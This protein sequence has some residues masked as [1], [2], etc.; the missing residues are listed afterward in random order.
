MNKVICFLLSLLMG[1]SA[2]AASTIQKDVFAVETRDLGYYFTVNARGQVL[3]QYLGK[4]VNSLNDFKYMKD[5]GYDRIR[6]QDREIYTTFG[7][8]NVDI[9]ALQVKHA[10][11]NMTTQL[12]LSEVEKKQLSADLIQ[13]TIKLKDNFYPFYVD[14]V[15]LAHQTSNVIETYTQIR[16][17]ESGSVVVRKAASSNLSMTAD[18][19]YLTH[20]YGE[21]SQEMTEVE[22][23]LNLGVKTIESQK[24]VRTSTSEHPTFFLSLNAPATETEG[25][26]ILGSLAWSGNYKL[27]FQYDAVNKMY[28][29]SGMNDFMSDYLLKSG[30]SFETPKFIFTYSDQGKGQASRNFHKWARDY[31][32]Y[33][34]RQVRPLVLNSWEGAYFNFD[35]KTIL[36]MIDDA[37]TMGVEMF[38]L[39]DGWFGNKYPRDNDK[40][41][42]GDWAINKKKL[43]NGLKPF[44]D[45]CKE[46]GMQFG[47]W[48]EPEMINPKSELAEKHPEW[49]MRS[50]NRE[51]LFLRNQLDLDLSNPQV[52]DF[53]FDVVDKTLTETPGITYVKWDENR[54]VENFG[55]TYLP[56]QQQSELWI[57]YVQ[58]LNK[59]YERLRAKYPNVIFQACAS[60]GGRSDYGTM[61]YHNEFWASDN[62]DA[63]SRVKINWGFSNIYPANAIA[64]HVSHVPNH[65]TKRV[66]PIKFRFDVAMAQRLGLELQPRKLDSTETAWTHLA[67]PEFKKIRE[68][69][70]LGELYRLL[71]PY[72]GITTAKMYVS[73]NKEKAVLFTYLLDHPSRGKLSF[74]KLQGL[75]PNK[76]YRLSEILPK[77]QGQAKWKNS[78]SGKVSKVVCKANGEILSGAYLMNVGLTLELKYKY[79]SF[80]LALEEVK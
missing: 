8:G 11:G 29:Q 50:P 60:G 43:P 26:V 32:Y 64:S 53:C 74:V 38:V 40:Q 30:E 72:K 59:V 45:R 79:D 33:G 18:R 42:L 27:Q 78:A 10:D 12:V 16:H 5:Y 61:K 80:V 69:V 3:Q 39:D 57:K 71:S 17:Q 68:T 6:L 24:G 41:G 54:H 14:V 28:V 63:E 58:G 4:K 46:K 19:Y 44:A 75:D 13:T 65:Q 25:E 76:Q 15:F 1:A 23:E 7:T 34:G 70:Q 77:D 31:G 55:S 67:V 56:A 48:V 21:W 62:T 47:I 73:E 9:P 20:F 2:M 52:Q 36:N 35:E 37:A 49:I 51:D 22:E 66:I